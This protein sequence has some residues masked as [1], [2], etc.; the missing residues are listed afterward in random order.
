MIF[1]IK[2]KYI[3]LKSQWLFLVSLKINKLYNAKLATVT[4]MSNNESPILIN[5]KFLFN[6][7]INFRNRISSIKATIIT[8]LKEIDSLSSDANVTT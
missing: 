8:T 1:T 4:P 7:P 6:C 3:K 2:K 5:S